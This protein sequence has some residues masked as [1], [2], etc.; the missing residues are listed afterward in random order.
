MNARALLRLNAD[1]GAMGGWLVG[2]TITDTD[3]GAVEIRSPGLDQD[4]YEQVG[5]ILRR[6][7]WQD[8]I[9]YHERVVVRGT[10]APS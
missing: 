7:G 3:D 2:Y 8:V 10:E 9:V 5:R 4:M 6:Q 1:V